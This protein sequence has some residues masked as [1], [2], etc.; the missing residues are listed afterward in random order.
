MLQRMKTGRNRLFNPN[1]VGRTVH[2][3]INGGVGAVMFLNSR[4]AVLQNISSLNFINFGDNNVFAAGKAFANQ[5]QYWKDFAELFNSD[6]LVDRRSGLRL[7]VNEAEIADIARSKGFR[8]VTNR[9]LQVGFTPTQIMDSFAIAVGGSTFYRNRI[10]TYEKEVDANGNKLYTP[11]QAKEL[12]FRDF[13]EEAKKSQQSSDPMMI[14][15]EQADA[16]ARYILAFANT[17][18]QM[19]L[20]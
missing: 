11:E 20:F 12:A 6:F 8:G 1:P 5:K 15:Q 4:S 18:S 17:P 3:M 16:V 14:S 10:K 7:N 13:T 9:L 2:D 19:Q